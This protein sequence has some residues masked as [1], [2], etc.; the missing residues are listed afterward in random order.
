MSRV[1]VLLS[2]LVLCPAAFAEPP[3]PGTPAPAPAPQVPADWAAAFTAYTTAYTAGDTAGA[4]G[5]IAQLRPLMERSIA[6]AAPAAAAP[7]PEPETRNMIGRREVRVDRRD[8]RQ[9]ARREAPAPAAADTPVV[10]EQRA[11][12]A[13]FEGYRSD[14]TTDAG[15]AAAQA[16]YADLERFAALMTGAQ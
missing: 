16:R 12:L 13:R 1:L 7:A 10:A 11:I 15:R 2:A 5:A 14:F 9:D 6:A 8:D 4:D 3:P